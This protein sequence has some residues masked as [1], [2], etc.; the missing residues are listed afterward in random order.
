MSERRVLRPADDV[1][2][3][4]A[5]ALEKKVRHA[6]RVGLRVDLLTVEV[7]SGLFTAGVRELLQG[8]LRHGEHSPGAAGSV[9]E[10]IGA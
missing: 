9:V 5:F 7:G 6:D 1:A 2:P 10:E 4:L 8:L 3:C